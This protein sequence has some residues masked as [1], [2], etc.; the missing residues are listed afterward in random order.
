MVSSETH[1]ESDAQ[2]MA[3]IFA[4]CP[5]R[6]RLV[7]ICILL[8]FSTFDVACTKLVSCAAFLASCQI[9]NIQNKQ[10]EIKIYLRMAYAKNIQFYSISTNAYKNRIGADESK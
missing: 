9:K 1:L 4:K 10:E 3:Y 7:R 5:L 6:V 2:C 8:R